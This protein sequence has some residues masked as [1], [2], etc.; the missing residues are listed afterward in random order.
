MP[1][2]ERE[3]RFYWLRLSE[4]FFDDFKIK[5]L[6]KLAGGDTLTIIYLKLQLNALR[7]GGV[8]KFRGLDNSIYEELALEID[9]E[10]DN[11]QILINYL[12]RVGLAEMYDDDNKLFLPEVVEN[13]GKEGSSAQRMRAM[14][15]RLKDGSVPLI[16]EE[17]TPESG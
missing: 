2:A 7:S 10:A 15:A 8:L 3:Q 6:R 11:V 4:R 1:M 16:P 12:V 17:T 14:R 9:E 5:R 13:T